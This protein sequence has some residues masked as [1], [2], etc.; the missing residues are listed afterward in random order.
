MEKT[1]EAQLIPY[2]GSDEFSSNGKVREG[3][4]KHTA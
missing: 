4:V 3:T 2:F 1:P